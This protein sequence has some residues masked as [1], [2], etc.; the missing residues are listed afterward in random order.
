MGGDSREEEDTAHI[1][2][3]EFDQYKDQNLEKMRA[4][5]ED[6]PACD[7]MMSQAVAKALIDQDDETLNLSSYWGGD[8]D[9]TAAEIEASALG[10]VLDWL[11]R[12][13]KVSDRER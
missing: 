10:V 5:I 11:K 1:L 2:V 13:G 3:D 12:N 7:G 9:I 6:L 8:H 4:D